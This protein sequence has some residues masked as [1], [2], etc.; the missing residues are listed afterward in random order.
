MSSC[1]YGTVKMKDGTMVCNL[2]FPKSEDYMTNKTLAGVEYKGGSRNPNDNAGGGGSQGGQGGGGGQGQGGGGSQGGQGGG[3]GGVL[4]N[5]AQS[6]LDATNKYRSS[7]GAPPLTW[8]PALAALAQLRSDV[9][10]ANYKPENPSEAHGDLSW[11][12]K[13]VGQNLYLDNYSASGVGSR[14]VDAWYGE[15]NAWK[16]QPKKEFSAETGHYTQLVWKDTTQV[17]CA[18]AEKNGAYAVTCDYYPPGNVQGQFDANV[19]S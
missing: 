17:G 19:P 10:A 16:A 12:G 7:S 6:I 9:N 5:E 8:N 3:G 15:V 14:A 13:R 4:S 11:D 18:V 2:K 1:L